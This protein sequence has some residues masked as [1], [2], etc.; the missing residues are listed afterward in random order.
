LHSRIVSFSVETEP[1]KSW[2][3]KL[4]VR[5]IE[6]APPLP[7]R[8]NT[9]KCQDFTSLSVGIPSIAYGRNHKKIKKG[10]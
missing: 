2:N 10:K 4:A 8:H 5:L 3:P 7:S 6:W 9:N 1:K